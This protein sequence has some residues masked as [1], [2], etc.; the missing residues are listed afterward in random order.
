MRE[1]YQLGGGA[2][3]IYEEQKVPA[4]FA[5]LAAATLDVVPLFGDDSI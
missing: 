1:T 2:A 5:P 3:A 4:I